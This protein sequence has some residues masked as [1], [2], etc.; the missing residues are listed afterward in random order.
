MIIGV[1]IDEVLAEHLDTLNAFIA[2][3][4]DMHFT[5]EMY[6]SYHWWLVWGIDK[7]EAVAIDRAFKESKD[8][9]NIAPV[10]GSYQGLKTLTQLAQVHIITSRP[11]FCQLQTEQW[12]KQHFGDL[13]YSLHFSECFHK[14]T[15]LPK[16]DY[17]KA[18]NISI[19]IEDSKD[20]SLSCAQQGITVFLM[21]KPWN[22]NVEHTNIIRV[23]NWFQ[24]TQRLNTMLESPSLWLKT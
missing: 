13:S 24:I 19:M 17:C 22:Q 9:A 11:E 5:K 15:G 1:D 21:N 2:Q 12:L 6:H 4:Y 18:N 10:A 23:N 8:F 20:I 16:H 3:H 14:N 7:A